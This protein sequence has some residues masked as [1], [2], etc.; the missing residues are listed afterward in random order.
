MKNYILLLTILLAFC[1]QS[2]AQKIDIADRTNTWH[3]IGYMSH[4]MYYYKKAVFGF[5]DSL[6]EY[7]GKKYSQYSW[8]NFS[9]RTD[10]GA[11]KVYYWDGTQEK[12][13][14]DYN[15]SAGDTFN[16]VA[17]DDKQ[18]YHYTVT[19]VDSM[20]ING[21]NHKVFHM[22]SPMPA[23]SSMTFIE[24]IGSDIGHPLFILNPGMTQGTLMSAGTMNLVCFSNNGIHPPELDNCHDTLLSVKKISDK[25]SMISVFPQPAFETL[26]FK[27]PIA[28]ADGNISITDIVGK[29]VYQQSFTQKENLQLRGLNLSGIYFYKVA[30]K[31]NNTVYSGKVIFQ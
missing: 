12:L 16:I 3:Y 5:A 19:K 28:I 7:N 4:P 9:I 29:Q 17:M 26:N 24:G 18:N 10:T 1:P 14:F 6:V 27:F 15:L 20:K 23:A 31:I 21:I 2:F 8:N 11:N 30:D 22:T 13:L 25:K